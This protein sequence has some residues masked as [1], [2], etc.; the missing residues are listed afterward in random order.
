MTPKPANLSPSELVKIELQGTITT[1][2]V[3]GVLTNEPV[4]KLSIVKSPLLT[5]A[6]ATEL[7]SLSSVRHLWLWCYV[8]RLALNALIRIPGVNVV[9]VLWLEGPFPIAGFGAAANLEVFRANCCMREGDLLAIFECKNLIEVGAQNAEV[10]HRALEA[11]LELPALRSLD[12]EG[13]CMNDAMAAKICMSSTLTALDIGGTRVTGAGLRH[14]CKM[15]QL[16]SLDLWSLPIAEEDLDALAQLTELDY[17]SIGNY[18]HGEQFN[19]ET[20][21][22]RL[23]AIPALKRLWLDG[24]AISPTQRRWLEERYEH[25]RITS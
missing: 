10:T 1:E 21:L 15:R 22:P 9:D 3:R 20:L 24:I 4:D 25:V 18:Q 6:N 23:A 5:L 8:D 11:L 12:L 2:K 19:A 13:S 16:R 17:L 14:L 7:T